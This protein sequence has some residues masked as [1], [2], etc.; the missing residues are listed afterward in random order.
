MLTP[1]SAA[2]LHWVQT[3]ELWI[4]ESSGNAIR[5]KATL[6]KGDYHLVEYSD[7]KVNPALPDSAFELDAPPGT[8][9]VPVN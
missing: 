4:P 8:R 2:S 5:Q 1:K 3:I 7:V 9:R 6:P